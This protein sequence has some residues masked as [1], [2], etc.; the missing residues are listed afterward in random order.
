MWS[1]FFDHAFDFSK[2]FN[3]FKR[4]LA[5]FAPSFP[6]FTYSH[7]SKMHATI[8]DKP[9]RDLTTSECNDLSLDARSG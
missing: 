2:A 6:V 8:Y 5:L 9:L 1:T 4:P 7:L 3:E